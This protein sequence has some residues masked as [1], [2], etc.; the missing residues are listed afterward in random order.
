MTKS[1]EQ[2]IDEFIN[3]RTWAVVGVSQDET[4]Y[5][6]R[7]FRDLTRA[8]YQVYAV[9]PKGGEI[10]GKPIYP[11]LKALPQKPAVVDVVVPP[12][13]TEQI[14]KEAATIGLQRIWMQPGAESPAA[15]QF[16]LDN[17]I[18]VVHDT[19]AMIQKRHWDDSSS[20]DRD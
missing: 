15:I 20:P 19:C 5:G 14:V 3:Q 1:Q 17:G 11:S 9:N 16:C 12:A 8:G 7:I 2:L 10:D 18:E 6:T 4:K 13:V